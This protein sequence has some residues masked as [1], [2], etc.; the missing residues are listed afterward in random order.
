MSILGGFHSR[1]ALEFSEMQACTLHSTRSH[2]TTRPSDGQVRMTQ[3]T[4]RPGFH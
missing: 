4:C 1:K 2:S 3:V